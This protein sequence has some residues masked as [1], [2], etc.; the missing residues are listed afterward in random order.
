MYTTNNFE[1]VICYLFLGYRNISER[2]PGRQTN[3]RA[4]IHVSSK[5]PKMLLHKESNGVL[6]IISALAFR[7]QLGCCEGSTQ[8]ARSLGLET[9]CSL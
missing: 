7:K 1:L 6:V 8:N 4:E 9:N 2:L 5:H 3:Q